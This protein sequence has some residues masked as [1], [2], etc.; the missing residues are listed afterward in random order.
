[1]PSESNILDLGVEKAAGAE[2]FI[3]STKQRLSEIAAR[4]RQERLT[5][6]VKGF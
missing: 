1:M 6:F 3:D 5:A 4:I 2:E